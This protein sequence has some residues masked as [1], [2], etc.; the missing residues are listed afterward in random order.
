MTTAILPTITIGTRPAVGDVAPD[1][2]LPSTAGT[3]VTLSD[4]RG[5]QHVLLAFFPMA[6]TSVCTTEMCAFGDDYD[7]FASRDVAV[8]PI[9]VDSV[10]TLKEFKAKTTAKVEFL[11]DVKRQVSAAY[12]LLFADTF[13]S[14]RAYVLIDKAGVV[15]W[16]HV[17]A[18]PGQRREN[19]EILAEIAKLG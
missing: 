3:D 9:S 18:T 14:N 11:S 5:K 8:L 1:F 7:Q 15:R 6:F 2:T 13:F 10:P 19:A 12:D 4:F 17:E 16:I